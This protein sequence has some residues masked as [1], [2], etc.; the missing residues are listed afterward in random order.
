MMKWLNNL[1]QNLRVC[2]Q[3]CITVYLYYS[4]LNYFDTSIRNV[5]IVCHISYHMYSN[6]LNIANSLKRV[7]S[8]IFPYPKTY[9]SKLKQCESFSII[10]DW[11]KNQ[12][13]CFNEKTFHEWYSSLDDNIQY[14]FNE[15]RK[16]CISIFHT[17]NIEPIVEMDEI[18][19]SVKRRIEGS[20]DTVFYNKHID[21]P[22][23]LFP[24]CSVYRCIVALNKNETISTH[25][26]CM[27]KKYYLSD[28]DCLGFDFNRE[29]HFIES[30]NKIN[31]EPRITLKIHFIVYRKYCY[32]LAMVLKEL[33]IKYDRNARNL[34][35]FTQTPNTLIKKLCANMILLT[36]KWTYLTEKYVSFHNVF[37]IS[38]LG[39]VSTTQY[40]VF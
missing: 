12:Q 5:G 14:H 24:F 3:D 35:I 32:N 16:D 34:F 21:G 26:D 15:I 40:L 8:Y 2:F 19:V 33:T 25:I 22:Y 6:D 13:S 29:I 20:S 31:N 1:N 9:F 30:N 36:T 10:N 37:L 17:S 18:Y 23:Y 4:L 27:Q 7:L 38:V 11:V 39:L 28:G